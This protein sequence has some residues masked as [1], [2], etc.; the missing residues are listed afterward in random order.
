[1]TTALS[2]Q[3][4]PQAIIQDFVGKRG[5]DV[6]A[7][8]LLSLLIDE[9][10]KLGITRHGGGVCCRRVGRDAKIHFWLFQSLLMASRFAAGFGCYPDCSWSK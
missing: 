7:F 4:V 1:M 10:N 9:K 2:L 8:D 6:T 3:A 5:F